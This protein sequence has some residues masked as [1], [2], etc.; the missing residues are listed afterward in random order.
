MFK[1]IKQFWWLFPA[2]AAAHIWR[3]R[4]DSLLHIGVSTAALLFGVAV[5]LGVAGLIWAGWK[6]IRQEKTPGQ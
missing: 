2:G 4:D 1:F 5:I 3:V 6:K